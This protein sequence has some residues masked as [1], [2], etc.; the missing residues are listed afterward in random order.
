V[1]GLSKP[2]AF[3]EVIEATV[4]GLICQKMAPERANAGFI[5]A[6]PSVELIF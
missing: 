5:Q 6:M 2:Q 4:S 3:E 1:Q